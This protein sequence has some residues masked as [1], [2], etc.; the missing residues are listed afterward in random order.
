[1]EARKL[2]TIVLLSAHLTT[3][4]CCL[5]CLPKKYNIRKFIWTKAP[6][7]T[8][9]TTDSRECLCQVDVMQSMSEKDITFTHN[10]LDKH[11]HRRHQKLVGVLDK[12]NVMYVHVFGS[13]LKVK[14]EIEY[15]DKVH[16]CA[17]IDVL[18]MSS[19]I[20]D[21][22][23]YDLRVWNSSNVATSAQP[24]LQAFKKATQRG[25]LIYKNFC[26]NILQKPLQTMDFKEQRI[27]LQS[28]CSNV[29]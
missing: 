29:A 25:H 12:K 11:E 22:N 14:E 16:N 26:Q 15:F 3:L 17:V 23:R 10:Y 18:S 19:F 1:M 7:W 13:R 5:K 4:E 9:L 24:C 20:G 6:I 28:F 8:Y 2:L 21:I 27:P